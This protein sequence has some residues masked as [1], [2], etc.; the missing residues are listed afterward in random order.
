MELEAK[1]NKF[2]T[3][4]DNFLSITSPK[5]VG[6][7]WVSSSP[8]SSREKPFQWFN[9]LF[10]G[11]LE[12]H[13]SHF[14]TQD[15]SIFKTNQFG[16]TFYLLHIQESYPK[17]EKAYQDFI[18]IITKSGRVESNDHRKILLLSENPQFFKTS[19]RKKNST[20]EHVE[21]FY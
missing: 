17:V 1:R 13:L 14:S 9:Y 2:I 21:Y 5:V 6:C 7:I 12:S 16:D 20:L 15:K 10:N 3:S 19:L 8:L 18:E 4:L 11:V